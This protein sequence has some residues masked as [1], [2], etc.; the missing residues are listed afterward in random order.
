MNKAASRLAACVFLGCLAG[1]GGGSSSAPQSSTYNPCPDRGNFSWEGSYV[2]EPVTFPSIPLGETPPFYDPSNLPSGFSGTIL[3]PADTKSY[4]G[5]RPAIVL[6]HGHNGTQC[7]LWYMAR[8]LAGDGYVTITYTQPYNEIPAT[9]GVDFDAVVSAIDFLGSQA[10]P[11]YSHTDPANIGV[12]GYSEGSSA[13]SYVPQ[14]P[15][16]YAVHAAVALDNLKHWLAGDS[17]A[18]GQGC[19]PPTQYPVA[20]T[21]P[22][23]GFAMDFVCPDNPNS[24]AADIKEAGWSWWQQNGLPSIELVMRGYTHDTFTDGQQDGGTSEQL[25]T[26]AYFVEAWFDRWLNGNYDADQS[27]L[28]CSV[29]GQATVNLLSENFLSGAYLDEAGVDTSDYAT[30]LGQNCP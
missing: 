2:A 28:A 27:L 25:R 12:V 6:Q 14:L 19:V 7:G 17:G 30:Y 22:T 21:V 1:C 23:L 18:A 16:A 13:A 3:R 20:P 10:N 15:E 5:P 8:A 11:Y 24:D 4:P 26:L 9:E 29:N